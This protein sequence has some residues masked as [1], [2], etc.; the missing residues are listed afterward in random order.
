M[1]DSSAG[2]LGAAEVRGEESSHRGCDFFQMRLQ[3][4]VAGIQE[5]DSGA[6]NVATKRFGARRDKVEI[7]LAPDRQQ[8][9]LRR[10]EILLKF[11]I[12]LHVVCVIEKQIELNVYVAGACE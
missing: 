2:G 4:K 1:A 3:R 12:E 8:W 9:R 5:L 11:R 6:R 7:V 10:T